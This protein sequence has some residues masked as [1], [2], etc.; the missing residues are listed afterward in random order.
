MAWSSSRS[1]SWSRIE[2]FLRG[3]IEEEC[4]TFERGATFIIA[5]R[6][7]QRITLH[8]MKNMSVR[9]NESDRQE[10]ERIA[11][12]NDLKPAAVF[13]AAVRHYLKAQRRRKEAR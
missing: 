9:L 5:C 11:Q 8:Y 2:V 13:R 7:L 4:V 3:F 10:I 6:A 1:A 12:A